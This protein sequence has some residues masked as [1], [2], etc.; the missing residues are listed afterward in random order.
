VSHVYSKLKPCQWG[1]GFYWEPCEFTATTLL[2]VGEHGVDSHELGQGGFIGV[3]DDCLPEAENQAQKNMEQELSAIRHVYTYRENLIE[4]F[5][6]EKASKQAK[7]G[8]T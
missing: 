8:A 1:E 6:Q 5:H 2:Y 7:E 3:C 4:R